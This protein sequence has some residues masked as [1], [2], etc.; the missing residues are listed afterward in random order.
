[1][2]KRGESATSQARQL[3]DLIASPDTGSE[4]LA[5]RGSV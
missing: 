5:Q 1:M 2:H 3:A 4:Q